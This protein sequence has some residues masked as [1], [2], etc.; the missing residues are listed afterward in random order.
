MLEKFFTCYG[1]AESGFYYMPTTLGYT[2]IAVCIL[3][4]LL[5]MTF[6]TTKKTHYMPA[7][8]LAFSAIALSLA[9]LTATFTHL[10][11]MPMGGSVTLFSMLFVTLVGYWFGA[12][13][14]FTVAIAYG[15]LQFITDPW[16]VSVPQVLFDYIFAFGALGISGFFTNSK[17]GLVKGY[18]AGVLGRLF[19]AFLSGVIFFGAYAADYNMSVPVYSIAYNGAYIGAEA[20]MTLILICIPPVA[21]GLGYVKKL[22]LNK[23]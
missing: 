5:V 1:D 17:H 9:Y 23:Q 8:E 12:R 7:K 10:Y 18:I 13:T 15:L 6:I 4:F 22:A 3:L 14:G 19:F 20:A 2:A 16:I 11:K 21:K